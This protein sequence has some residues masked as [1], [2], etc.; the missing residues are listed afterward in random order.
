MISVIR[1]EQYLTATSPFNIC[2]VDLETEYLEKLTN[3]QLGNIS[4]DI[5]VEPEI[6]RYKS[7]DSLEIPVLLYKPKNVEK[8][9]L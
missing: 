8:I 4:E 5:L 3:A 1:T 9:T 6:I 7:F 2:T